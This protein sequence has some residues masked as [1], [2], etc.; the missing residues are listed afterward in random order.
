MMSF[1]EDR[2]QLKPLAEIIPILDECCYYAVNISQRPGNPPFLC[3]LY[4]G[5]KGG[6][7]RGL[8]LLNDA[9]EL[10]HRARLQVVKRIGIFEH[11]GNIK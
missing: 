7:Y 10:D 3:I 9:V 1:E 5:F 4:T 6:G 2:D 8:L 11:N